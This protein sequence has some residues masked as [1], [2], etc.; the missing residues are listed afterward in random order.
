MQPVL[1]DKSEVL[2][3]I[4][5][6]HV[7]TEITEIRVYRTVD[8]MYMLGWLMKTVRHWPTE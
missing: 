3:K 5:P 7:E 6:R 8:Y 1:V 4:C 2:T